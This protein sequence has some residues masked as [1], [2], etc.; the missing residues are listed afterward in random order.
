MSDAPVCA[1]VGV[2]PGNGLALARRFAAGGQRVALLARRAEALAGFADQIEGAQAFPCDVTDPGAVESAFAAIGERMGPVSTLLYNA[3]SG[4]W[5]TIDKVSAADLDRA[6]ATNAGGLFACAKQ[7]LPGMRAAGSGT[8]GIVGATA[9]LRGKAGTLTFA[10]GKA[11]QRS[12]AQSLARQLGPERIHVFYAI[13][14]GM[15]DLATTRARMPDKTDDDFLRPSDIAQ[16][17]WQ[18]AQQP[19]SAWTFELDLRPF[20]ESW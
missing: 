6:F 19:S 17:M 3:G 16:A 15:I 2:G 5:G 13:I 7:V 9:S 18:V 20:K 10:A 4:S 8:I 11:A 1:V 14:D 12:I